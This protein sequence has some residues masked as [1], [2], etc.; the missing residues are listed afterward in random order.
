MRA[1][2]AVVATLLRSRLHWVFSKGVMLITVTGRK[3]GRRYTTPVQ[4]IRVERAIWALS[5]RNR[6]WWRNIGTGSP[7]AI[8]LKRQAVNGHAEVMVTDE[9]KAPWHSIYEGS[10]LSRAARRADAVFVRIRL[11]P[12]V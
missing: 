10:S 8:L 2:N 12:R 7:V 9:A 11:D 6:R 5:R 1:A 4:Y 3:S